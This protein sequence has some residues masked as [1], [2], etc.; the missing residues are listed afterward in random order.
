[1]KRNSQIEPH[2]SKKGNP[3]FILRYQHYFYMFLKN[4]DN[5]FRKACGTLVEAMEGK[6]MQNHSDGQTFYRMQWIQYIEQHLAQ[7]VVRNGLIAYLAVAMLAIPSALGSLQH[8][9]PSIEIAALE[10]A[11]DLSASALMDDLVASPGQEGQTVAASKPQLPYHEHIMQA[12]EAY[13]V[14]PTLIRAIIL[15]ESSYNPQAVSKRGAQGL[16]QLM[17][18]TARSLGLFDSFDPGRNIDAGVRYFRSLMDRFDGNVKLALAAYNAGSRYVRQ[19]G[20]VP[21]FE[22]T[23]RYI[24]KVLHYQK[25]FQTQMAVKE[26]SEPTV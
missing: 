2:T 14:D 8:S 6:Y 11:P 4:F 15:A 26:T 24:Q 19:Y 3:N 10:M 23:K 22:A 1:M 16:M 18:E 13:D 17:P 20:G 9:L 5:L 7:R 25:K 21:P 12:A